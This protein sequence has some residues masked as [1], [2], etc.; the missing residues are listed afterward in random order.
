MSSPIAHELTSDGTPVTGGVYSASDD[1]RNEGG[2]TGVEMSTTVARGRREEASEAGVAITHGKVAGT[3]RHLR[4]RGDGKT[5][6]S[7]F[8]ALETN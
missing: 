2:A 4:L 7:A 8:A 1:G 3:A 5:S 6:P